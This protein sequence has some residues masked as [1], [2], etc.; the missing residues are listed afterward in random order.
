MPPGRLVGPQ[1]VMPETVHPY[2]AEV[3]QFR[4][5]CYRTK[6]VFHRT[7]RLLRRDQDQAGH[8]LQ[9]SSASRFTAGCFG[10]LLL[11]QCR[12]RPER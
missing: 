3:E 5:V 11:I 10:F 9:S 12:E 6:G 8:R 7:N 1:P 4:F 2:R